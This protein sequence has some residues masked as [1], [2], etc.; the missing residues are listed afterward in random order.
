[1]L[2]L[3]VNVAYRKSFTYR[4]QYFKCSNWDWLKSTVTFKHCYWW[5]V[6]KTLFCSRLLTASIT[7]YNIS[8]F[9]VRN[10]SR[11]FPCKIY[12]KIFY[13]V[14]KANTKKVKNLWNAHIHSCQ[15]YLPWFF[16][17]FE[18]FEMRHILEE[19]LATILLCNRQQR[20]SLTLWGASQA[21]DLKTSHSWPSLTYFSKNFG[22]PQKIIWCVYSVL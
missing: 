14:W 5:C 4:G 1:M 8:H 13:I 17:F 18:V 2:S 15:N 9:I 10:Q 19:A 16:I 20:S 22:V 6:I 21:A 7:F 3:Y 12:Y 11:T